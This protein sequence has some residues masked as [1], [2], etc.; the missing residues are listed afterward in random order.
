MV[1]EAQ[2]CPVVVE[3]ATSVA[4]SAAT[5]DNTTCKDP[6]SGK[7]RIAFDNSLNCP[8]ADPD[9]VLPGA[10]GL[11][12]HSGANDWATAIAWDKQG[13][14]TANN[15]GSDLFT[16]TLDLMDYYGMLFDSLSNIKFVLN[17]GVANP[18][19]AWA[20]AGRDDRNGGFGGDEP[21][22]DLELK[23]FYDTVY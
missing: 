3:K 11:G 21:C 9:G 12:F 2:A 16:L 22:L 6:S 13:A 17:N 19:D 1:A 14:V 20:V 10:A 5:G 15:N 7:I 8:E 23:N 18:S 4:L